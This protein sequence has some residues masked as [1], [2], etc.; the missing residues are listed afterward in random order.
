[1]PYHGMQ[2]DLL[3]IDR[4]SYSACTWDEEE[5]G[6]SR[7]FFA[8]HFFFVSTVCG[9]T[10]ASAEGKTDFSQ[11]GVSSSTACPLESEMPAVEKREEVSTAND[12][13]NDV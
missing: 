7:R 13:I 11:E 4:E 2:S 5:E 6:D 3:V 10:L 9:W 8:R 1:M 12:Y